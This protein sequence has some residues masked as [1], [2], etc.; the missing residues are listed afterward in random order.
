VTLA[1]GT[2]LGPYEILAPLGAGGMGEVYRARDTRLE[3]AVAVKVLPQRLSSSPESRQRFER[4]AKTISQLTH[5][6]I[7]AL[8]DVGREGETEYLVMEL[9]EGETLSDRLAKGA[10][11]LEQTLRY[12][13]EIAG[14]LEKAHR[15]GIVHRDLKPGNVMLT[16]SGVKLLD[17][18]LA[19]GMATPAAP[20]SLTSL[21]TQ[22]GL[23]QEGTILGT[24]QYMA[25][26]QLEGKESDAR[27]DIWAFGCVLYE[28][29]TGRKAFS[30]TSQASLI[31]SIMS[32][33]P[34]SIS[35]LQPLS[36]SALDRVVK[37]CL[38]K[39]PED[40]WQ[41]AGDVGK[42]LRW[43]SEGSAASVAAPAAVSARRKGRERF[44]WLTALLLAAATAALLSTARARRSAPS[45]PPVRFDILPPFE[46]EFT[47]SGWLSPDGRSVAFVSGD[48]SGKERIWI[49]ALDSVDSKPIEGT[50]EVGEVLSLAW[51]PDGGSLAFFS[52][53]D[54]SIKRIAVS[55]G[56]AQPVCAAQT[57]FGLSWGASGVLAFVPAY[58][59]GIQQVS[60]SGGTPSPVTS[61]DRS[62]GEVA[63]LWPRFLPDGK[64]FLFFDRTKTGQASHQGW[65]ASA[66]LG[67]K[68]VRRIRPADAFV[69]VAQG[70]LLFTIAGSLYTQPFDES[71][72]TVHGEAAIIPGRLFVNGSI[73]DPYVEVAGPNLVFRSD[74]PKLRRLVFV[75]RGGRKLSEVGEPQP[76]S[77][78]L[79]I[80]PDG[81]QALVSRQDPQ[82]GIHQLWLVDLSRGTSARSGSGVEEESYPVWSPDGQRFLLN[83]DRD[84][85]Y[86][87][88]IRRLDGSSPDEVLPRSDYD[89]EAE[90][91]SRDGRFI[92]FRNYDPKRTGLGILTLGSRDPPTY[93][94]GSELADGFRLSPDGRWL[95]WTSAES[96]RREV[97]VQRF[98]DGSARQQVSVNGGAAAR[99]SPDGREIFFVSPDRKLM[100]ASFD[101]RDGLPQISIP[102]PL[103]S[104]SRAQ[105]EDAYVGTTA[106]NWDVTPD[107]SKFLLFLPVSETDPS[108]LTVVL[109]W[110]AQLKR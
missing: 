47:S 14:A 33:E 71:T 24:F 57:T 80:S 31:S 89:K 39:D 28:M 26:E 74:P 27:T 41:S 62:N 99:F 67:T 54:R 3:R 45:P 64:R 69:G 90:D 104:M 46:G 82:R 38:A 66:L 23:T 73:V 95:L 110:T 37:S 13:M 94:K 9:L 58:G 93:L 103:F 106:Q 92:L 98:P 7:C 21:P 77:Q 59:T 42:E 35:T 76:Y 70:Q 60:A 102:K 18:G 105:M 5:P 4:E 86:D 6:H 51:S 34:A 63:H 22:Q 52:G 12:G 43:I 16:K 11:P 10:L 84:G 65:I 44:V 68:G 50:G 109:N 91:W 20:S 17:F 97:Y 55:G 25:P 15:Q 30:G 1:A 87:L 48:G 78:R 88:V 8:Y 85:P 75:D 72:L 56:T 49:R 101:S 36:P 19:K 2:R 100:S 79:A 108:V 96:G 81:R 29:A 40:R 107:G 32:G 61:L 83:W 53:A